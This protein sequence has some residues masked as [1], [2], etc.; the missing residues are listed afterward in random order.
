MTG[1]GASPDAV[2][3]NPQRKRFA[4]LQGVV[5]GEPTG[6]SLE[7]ARSVVAEGGRVVLFGQEE[8]AG[9]AAADQLGPQALFHRGQIDVEADV[10]SAI[11]ACAAAHRGGLDFIFNNATVPG[12]PTPRESEEAMWNRMMDI[13]LNSVVLGCKHA[14][15]T[16]VANG[17]GG[18]IV[19]AVSIV[20]H[21]DDP[22]APIWTATRTGLLGLTRAVAV[23]YAPRGIRANCVAPVEGAGPLL[24]KS[25][26][27][28]SQMVASH[29]DWRSSW[30]SRDHTQPCGAARVVTF[31]L[32]PAAYRVNGEYMTAAAG[33]LTTEP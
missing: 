1:A 18:A 25:L 31:L 15:R 28:E 29:I 7:V 32:S 8:R 22:T 24:R 14:V 11:R 3:R 23:A 2:A 21:V 4:G 26:M 20:G 6:L 19:N 5:T 12:T 10:M 30:S 27:Q 16:M 33:R 9:E 13:N 17:G